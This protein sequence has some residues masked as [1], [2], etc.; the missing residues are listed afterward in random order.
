MDYDIVAASGQQGAG[1]RRGQ[2]GVAVAKFCARA[3]RAGDRHRQ[4]AGAELH[5][6]R[7]RRSATAS[8]WELGGHEQR[9]FLERRPDRA[10]ARRARDPSCVAARASRACAITG[11]IELASRVHPRRRSSAITGTNGKSTMTALAGEMR[12]QTGRPT[13]VGG[14]LGTPLI[15]ARR[16]AGGDGAR[17]S[18]SSSC[19]ASSSRP[20]ETLHPR[21]AALLNITPDHLDRYADVDALRRGQAAHLAANLRGDDVAVVNADDAVLRARRRRRRCARAS[22]P[23]RCSRASDAARATPSS[24]AIVDGARPGGAGASAIRS[25]SCT[26]S[27]ATTSATRWRRSCSCAAASSPAVRRGARGA[28]RVPAAAA[29]HAARRRAR[30]VALLRRLQGH[31]RRRGRRRRSTASR[32][33]SC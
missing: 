28:A 18:S 13:F 20:C 16:H 23:T 1:R 33:R 19:R 29:P 30:G 32:G 4:R 21:A 25:P 7:C 26:S 5:G 3:R 31:Q 12:E 15:D 10:V 24:T 27:A 11:E 2:T 14:N 17:G 9:T 22:A 8:R 6:A